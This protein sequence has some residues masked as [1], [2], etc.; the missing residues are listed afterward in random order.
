MTMP[1]HRRTYEPNP[2]A[3]LA[4]VFDLLAAH[5]RF[6][7]LGLKRP[8]RLGKG[9]RQL[10]T[11]WSGNLKTVW[12]YRTVR[13]DKALAGL[14]QEFFHPGYYAA[15]RP[16]A[17]LRGS[18]LTHYLFVGFRRGFNP[19]ALFDTHSYLRANPDVAASQVNPLLHYLVEGRK[20]GRSAV[21]PNRKKG[22]S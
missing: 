7:V 19:S 22:A 18:S 10:G 15:H 3:A 21:P 17:Q 6:A 1:A 9:I 13:A 14:L 16:D 8:S 5:P 20:E 2:A 4:Q 11:Y 12:L